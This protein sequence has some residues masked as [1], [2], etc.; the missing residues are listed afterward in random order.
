MAMGVISVALALPLADNLAILRAHAFAAGQTVDDAAHDIVT[1]A[2][3]P[4][5]LTLDSNA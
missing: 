3:S 4:Y 1:G 2:L 5:R